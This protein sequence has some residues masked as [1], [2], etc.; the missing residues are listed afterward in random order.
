MIDESKLPPGATV[1]KIACPG[2]ARDTRGGPMM[3]FKNTH[4]GLRYLDFLRHVKKDDEAAKQFL[5]RI[6]TEDNQP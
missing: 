4:G 2:V 3:S 6:I 5:I 1:H